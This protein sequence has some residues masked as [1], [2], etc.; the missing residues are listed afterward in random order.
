M[1]LARRVS[2]VP[3]DVSS[4]LGTKLVRP[5]LRP[6]LADCQAFSSDTSLA[7][8]SLPKLTDFAI[9]Q[10][11]PRRS[12]RHRN[13]RIG[14]YR[15]SAGR[16]DTDEPKHRRR[17]SIEVLSSMYQSPTGW[18]TAPARHS[19][20]LQLPAAP[21]A[22]AAMK[23]WWRPRTGPHSSQLIVNSG[24]ANGQQVRDLKALPCT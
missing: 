7:G 20:P 15:V 10:S 18:P 21:A 1:L 16:K 3:L 8:S 14:A 5:L 2:A 24:I 13:L 9:Q 6:A 12:C 11:L 22:R 17:R 23:G 4:W 19:A